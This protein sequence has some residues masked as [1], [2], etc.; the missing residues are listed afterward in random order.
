MP[1]DNQ[2]LTESL[3]SR[4]AN[5]ILSNDVQHAGAH[6]SGEHG[7]RVVS[8]ARDGQNQVPDFTLRPLPPRPILRTSRGEAVNGEHIPEITASEVDNGH[9]RNPKV[10]Q[11]VKR[12]YEY[13]GGPLTKGVPV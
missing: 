10:R 11:R 6:V 8:H 2:P 4:R 7:H 9:R 13:C 3:R 1:I 12:E 5:K